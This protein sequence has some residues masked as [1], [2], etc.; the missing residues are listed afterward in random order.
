MSDGVVEPAAK[1]R[2][3][4]PEPPAPVSEPLE[5]EDAPKVRTRLRLYII[6]IA[7]YVSMPSKYLITTY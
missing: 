5:I 1:E 3:V 7:L 2:E 6:L 4:T